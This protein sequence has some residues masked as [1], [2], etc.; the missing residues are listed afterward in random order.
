M[1]LQGRQASFNL[2]SKERPRFPKQF[3]GA[4]ANE[5]DGDGSSSRANLQVIPFFANGARSETL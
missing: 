5:A 4:T 2:A 1:I 3:T